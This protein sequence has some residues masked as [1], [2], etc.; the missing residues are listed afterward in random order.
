[1]T[2]ILVTGHEGVIGTHLI[3]KLTNCEVIT[4]SINGILSIRLLSSLDFTLLVLLLS[5]PAAKEFVENIVKIK[6]IIIFFIFLA[7]IS[8]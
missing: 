5:D 3:K 6:S 8:S 2:K 1:M 4:D 7:I